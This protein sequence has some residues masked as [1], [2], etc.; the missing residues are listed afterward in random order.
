[1]HAL[2]LH[3][4]RFAPRGMRMHVHARTLGYACACPPC[5]ALQWEHLRVVDPAGQRAGL[6]LLPGRHLASGQVLPGGPRLRHGLLQLQRSG[7]LL[8]GCCPRKAVHRPAYRCLLWTM[9]QVPGGGNQHPQPG[10]DA[11][12]SAQLWLLPRLGCHVLANSPTR[13]ALLLRRPKG[14]CTGC[15]WVAPRPLWTQRRPARGSRCWSRTLIRAPRA[16]CHWCR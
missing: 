10:D 3:H 12:C 1:M 16:R 14:R 4:L 8:G 6:R 11:C 7:H 15:C 13:P 5:S 9:W 2:C